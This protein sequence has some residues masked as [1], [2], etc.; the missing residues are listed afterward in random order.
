M[1]SGVTPIKRALIS[2]SNKHNV[3][4]LGKG[5]HRLQ[6]EILSTGSTAKT[7]RDSGIPVTDVADV[8]QFPEIMDGRVKTLHP[9][10][11]G[12]ILSR[13][14]Q[15]Q[16]VMAEHQI[17]P[18]DLV[19]VNLYPFA[20][21]VAKPD[22]TLTNAI[23]NI[24]IGGPTMIRAAA[25]NYAH[26][27]VVVDTAD[28]ARLLSAL[29]Q[30]GGTNEQLRYDL[31]KK[32]FAHTAQYDANIIN[33]LSST[34]L[35]GSKSYFP[36]TVGL[37]LE[38]VQ[39]L[40]YGENAH[41]QAAFYRESGSTHTCIANAKQQ[42][43]KPLSYNNIADSDAALETVK[44]FDQPACVIIKHANPCG[45]AIAENITAAY[46]RAYQT[47]AT[48]AFGGIIAFNHELDEKTAHA[49]IKQQF[50]EVIIA[51]A[52]STQAATI[53]SHKAN[54]R[55][56]TVGEFTPDP[57]YRELKRV[58]GGY[59]L[60]DHDQVQLDRQQLNCVT[61]QQPDP[62]MLN[63]LIFAWK[64][65]AMV[66][67]NAIVYAKDQATIGIGAGQMSRVD[68]AKIGISK[69]EEAG[70]AINGSVMASDAFF[71]F[72]DSVDF[73]AQAGVIAIIQ[74]GGSMRDQEV[75]AAADE[76]GIVMV[77]TG[78]RHFRH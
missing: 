53:I 56:L 16:Q 31:A 5:L 73:A 50:V 10:I 19:I 6:V 75:I 61:K 27:T 30:H 11:H 63:D 77:F 62:A 74:P 7:L 39:D 29:E 43:G 4:E 64:V 76:A 8:T 23:E 48:S 17:Q 68:S 34:D 51:P 13:R 37:T 25:K 52:V 9:K 3:I 40:R 57:V 65:A 26:V 28:Y 47:D 44:L 46:Q 59:L 54:I 18:I 66:K 60:Q 72:R 38:K 14:Q 70:L 33:Y 24:D 45:V 35:S 49:I 2:V 36:Q 22:C 67:S 1:D 78:E 71:P 21:T 15:D 41:Q 55:L 69:A 42:Q 58:N 32:A 12:G 20:Q